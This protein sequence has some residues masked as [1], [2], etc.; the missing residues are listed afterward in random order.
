LEE[1]SDVIICIFVQSFE[2]KTV[3]SPS[4]PSSNHQKENFVISLPPPMPNPLE[5]KI[6]LIT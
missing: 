3:L 5:E 6:D 1:K 2:K 4:V